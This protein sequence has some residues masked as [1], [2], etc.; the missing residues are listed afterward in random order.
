MLLPIVTTSAAFPYSTA[1]SPRTSNRSYPPT[2]LKA[3]RRRHLRAPPAPSHSMH[4]R[5]G[6]R[7]LSVRPRRLLHRLVRPR[8][9]AARGDARV[10]APMG[11]GR[12]ADAALDE[13][14]GPFTVVAVAAVG[15]IA[16]AYNL[17]VVVVAPVVARLV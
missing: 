3:H 2:A 14:S 8:R 11:R 7:L 1:S 17:W 16:F 9:T 10:R 13:F 12:S 6:A 15:G 5:H 4:P